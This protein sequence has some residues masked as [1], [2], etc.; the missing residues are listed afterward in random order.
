MK[1]GHQAVEQPP[2]NIALRKGTL[3]EECFL[4]SLSHAT[5]FDSLLCFLDELT[6]IARLRT[7]EPNLQSL[8]LLQLADIL[9]AFSSSRFVKL[10]DDVVDFL[11]GLVSSDEYNHE[12][13]ISVR[14]SCWKG[15]QNCLNESAAV[16]TQDYS[17]NLEQCMDALF[18]M[19][20]WSHSSGNV[21]SYQNN[22]NTEW[23]EAIACLGKARQGWLSDFLLVMHHFHLVLHIQSHTSYF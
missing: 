14:V 10:L 9:R 11:H 22:S 5:Q 2:H 19:L 21:Q 15:L 23:A 17:Y 4:F 1:Y 16:E 6:D 7:L 3:R 13:K 20:Q 12:D 18:T 8:V